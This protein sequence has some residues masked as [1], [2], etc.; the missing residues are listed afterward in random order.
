M[1]KRPLAIVVTIVFSVVG[2]VGAIVIGH[3]LRLAAWPFFAAAIVF[4]R[5][6]RMFPRR[7]DRVPGHFSDEPPIRRAG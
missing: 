4:G 7:A 1:E 2:I 3:S 5:D 6:S